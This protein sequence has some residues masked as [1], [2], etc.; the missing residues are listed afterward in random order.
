[1]IPA[2]G[3][4]RRTPATYSRADTGV[5]WLA[6][7]DGT[8]YGVDATTGHFV[9][10]TDG[11]GVA[12]TGVS[13]PAQFGAGLR[14]IDMHIGGGYMFAIVPAA[15]DAAGIPSGTG[16]VYRATLGA[17][18][19]WADITPTEWPTDTCGRNS[20]LAHDGTTLLLGAYGYYPMAEDH[21][22]VWRST[23]D[24]TTWAVVVEPS[25]RHVHALRFDPST[26]G[27]AWLSM[28]EGT[29]EGLYKSTDSGA[30]WT[31][32]ANNEYFIDMAFD[33]GQILLEGEGFVIHVMGYTPG[34]SVVTNEIDRY[35]AESATSLNDWRGTTRAIH[36]LPDGRLFYTTTNEEGAQ[37][38]RWGIWLATRNGS[39]WGLELLEAPTARWMV[40]GSTFRVG[41]RLLC[42][43]YAMTIP[44][45][46]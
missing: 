46:P 43:R 26:A 28:G 34:A 4:Y 15:V 10:T 1:M 20:M 3:A 35:D 23:D 27:V 21:G 38:F 22:Y 5:Y 2:L 44:P 6:E 36:L 25:A 13:A 45:A 40:V 30:T 32:L 8:A 9:T 31:L 29:G 42:Y 17:W 24:G 19:S 39:G 11:V 33:T 7:H 12:S 41:R 37:G 16:T 14:P 18:T